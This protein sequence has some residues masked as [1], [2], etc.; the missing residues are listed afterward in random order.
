ML[1][2]GGSYQ[3]DDPY[4]IIYQFTS[5][6]DSTQERYAAFID[7][8]FDDMERSP[9][10]QNVV[11]LMANGMLTREGQIWLDEANRSNISPENENI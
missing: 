9:Y 10:V 5:T 4:P 3:G 8:Q 11:C 6:P 1:E 2:N 7:E